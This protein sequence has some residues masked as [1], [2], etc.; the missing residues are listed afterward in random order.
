MQCA[1]LKQEMLLHLHLHLHLNLL[2][3]HLHLLLLLLLLLHASLLGL[4]VRNC[5]LPGV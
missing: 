1:L 5:L 2:H 3:L 4:P